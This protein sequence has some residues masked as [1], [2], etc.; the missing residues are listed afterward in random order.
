M[1]YQATI[2]VPVLN[3][4]GH[5]AGKLQALQGF[6]DRCQLLLVDGG[7][8]DDSPEIA[9]SLVD[10][11]ILGPRGRAMQMNAGA[12][13]AEAEILLFLHADT[14][15]PNNAM[16]LIS[17]A[18]AEGFH[19]GRFDVAFDNP[20]PIFKLIA[21]M[22]NQRSRL[23]GIATGDQAVFMTR[24]A[25]VAVGGFPAIALMEDIAISNKLKKLGKPCCLKA[26]VQTSERRWLQQGIC[27]TILL[28]WR[29]RLAYFFGADPDD[30]AMRYYGRR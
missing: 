19:W 12:L 20:K 18:I 10:K 24:P 5:L 29:L 14:R 28:M 23:T 6:R 15:L 8:H 3:E 27:K 9:K 26:K 25:F 1:T 22:M 21:F 4:A 16:D 7:S 2:V 17:Q 11:V 30:L 13:Q